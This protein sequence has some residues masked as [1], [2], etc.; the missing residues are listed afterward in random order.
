MSFPRASAENLNYDHFILGRRAEENHTENSSHCN[1]LHPSFGSIS[2]WICTSICSL[3]IMLSVEC[4]D[5]ILCLL[6]ATDFGGRFDLSS[7]RLRSSRGKWGFLLDCLVSLAYVWTS[8]SEE[9]GLQSHYFVSFLTNTTQ[10]ITTS[11][12]IKFKP[13][14]SIQILALRS[15]A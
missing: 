12:R 1:T 11:P 9:I 8:I 15:F 7:D 13:A 2:V 10:W 6:L 4:S 3:Q 5:L 14:L